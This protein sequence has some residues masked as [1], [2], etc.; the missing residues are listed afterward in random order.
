MDTFLTIVHVTVCF[1][2][3]GVVLLQSGRE[4]GGEI[5]GGSSVRQVGQS[6][7][8]FMERLTAIVAVFFVVTS[9][10]LAAKGGGSSVMGSESKPK[11]EAPATAPAAAGEAADSKGAGDVKVEV[12]EA[13]PAKEAASPAAAGAEDQAPAEQPESP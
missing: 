9:V 3:I 6:A 7:N 11:T 8:V 2:L 12:K 10:L 1:I 5:G 13:D 4:G